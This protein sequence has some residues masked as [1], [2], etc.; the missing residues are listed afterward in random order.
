MGI[1][2]MLFVFP[3]IIFGFFTLVSLPIYLDHS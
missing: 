3:A 2:S 1:L